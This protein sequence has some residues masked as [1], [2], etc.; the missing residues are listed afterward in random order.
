MYA[1]I[2]VPI[3]H[4]ALAQRG[5]A[6]AIALAKALG[7]K[8][9]ILHVVDLRSMI[10][11]ANGYVPPPQLIE[12]WTAMGEE[13]VAKAVAQAREAGVEADSTVCCDP[14]LR[15]SDAVVAEAGKC[16]A[17]LIV[18][19]THG[20][21]GFSRLVMGSDAELVLRSSHVPV[22]LVRGESADDR[23]DD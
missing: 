12:Q 3:D 16:K 22:M 11:G 9:R 6:E 8:L 1:Q 18:M 23:G 20:R 10:Q 2:L 7:S 15:I 5:T 13:L 21:R 17:G 4:G 14:S 19:G